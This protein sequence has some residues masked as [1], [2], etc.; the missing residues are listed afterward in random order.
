MSL[1][2]ASRS[3]SSTCNVRMARSN[4][5]ISSLVCQPLMV[6]KGNPAF[7]VQNGV[8]VAF[9]DGGHNGRQHSAKRAL[10]EARQ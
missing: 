10:Q 9:G 3:A 4:V 7:G 2:S 6:K 5:S 1:S 8:S